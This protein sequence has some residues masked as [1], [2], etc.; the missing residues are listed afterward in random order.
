L[1]GGVGLMLQEAVRKV[2]VVTRFIGSSL[3]ES[4][5]FRFSRPYAGGST[6]KDIWE[7]PAFP[8]SLDRMNAVTT[9]FSDSVQNTWR[10]QSGGAAVVRSIGRGGGHP[11]RGGPGA[12]RWAVNGSRGKKG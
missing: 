1:P 9:N 5:V 2:F 4:G 7:N 10:A 3:G 12:V 8:G 11:F 6:Q